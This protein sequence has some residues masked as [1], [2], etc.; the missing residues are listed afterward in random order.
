M[1]PENAGGENK[2]PPIPVLFEDVDVLAI[3][4]PAGL[5]VHT[6]GRTVEPS[7]VD[8]IRQTHPEIEGVGEPMQ[9]QNGETIDRPGIVHRLDRDTSGVLVIAKNQDAFLFLKKQFQK[10]EI[11]KHYRAFVYGS[12]KDTAGTID[13]PIGRS[14][15]DFRRWSAGKGTHL[16]TRPAVTRY[17]VLLKNKEAT[18]LDL[19]PLTGRTHQI[20]VHLQTIGHSVVCDS[21]YAPSKP[22]ILGFTR[23]ALHALSLTLMLPSGEQKTCE[24]PEPE[25]FV[26]AR[27]LLA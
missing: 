20:R 16:H 21:R 11:E 18:Y 1:Q 12:M 13:K 27:R 15:G 26:R 4:K 24:A 22:P 8:W 5:I 19:E 25:D 2:L 23:L 3:N 7:V 9:L 6:D 14:T 17:T 10:H